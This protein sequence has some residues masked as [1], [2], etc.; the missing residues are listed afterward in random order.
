M[1]PDEQRLGTLVCVKCTDTNM[2]ACVCVWGGVVAKCTRVCVG[3]KFTHVCLVAVHY[4]QLR[5]AEVSV[6]RVMEIKSV[7]SSCCVILVSK[8]CINT[9]LYISS[10]FPDPTSSKF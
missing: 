1:D 2:C 5:V 8:R 10:S 6:V 9:S 7:H 3:V 4:L